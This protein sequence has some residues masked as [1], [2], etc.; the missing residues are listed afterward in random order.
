ML[1]NINVNNINKIFVYFYS[2][3][4][5]LQ[6]AHNYYEIFIYLYILY[7]IYIFQIRCNY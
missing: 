6:V 7:N 4:L 3:Q 1:N 2:F 5:W